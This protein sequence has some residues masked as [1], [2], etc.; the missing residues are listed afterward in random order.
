MSHLFLGQKETQEWCEKRARYCLECDIVRLRHEQKQLRDALKILF[1]LLEEYA[2][3]WYSEEHHKTSVAAI[4]G[5]CD[6]NL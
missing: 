4:S 6:P 1:E 3:P 2:P 5:I